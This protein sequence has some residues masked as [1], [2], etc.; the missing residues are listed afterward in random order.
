MAR[1]GQAEAV[2]TSRAAISRACTR[3]GAQAMH[4][5][6]QRGLRPLAPPDAPG[7]MCRALRAMAPGGSCVEV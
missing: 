6:A 3:L 2:Q 4:R 1:S 5:L 7:S